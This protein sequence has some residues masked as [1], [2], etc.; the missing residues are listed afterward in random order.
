MNI[1]T[2]VFLIGRIVFGAFWLLAGAN[3]FMHLRAT[4][5]YV[6]ARGVPFPEPAVAI[7]GILLMCGG[8]SMLLGAY[9]AM[10]MVLLIVFLLAASFMLHRYWEMDTVHGRQI[11]Q[12]NFQKNMALAGALLMFVQLPHPWPLSLGR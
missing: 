3:H 9:P 4:T 10:G 6:K 12:T 2:I 1:T 11:E 5:E 8:L 7:G